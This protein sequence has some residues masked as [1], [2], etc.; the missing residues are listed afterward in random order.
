[1]H[2]PACKTTLLAPVKIEADLPAM[3]CPKC[4]GALLP[5]LYYRYWQERHATAENDSLEIGQPV[6]SEDSHTALNCPKCGRIMTKYKVKGEVGNRL[7][8][9]ASCD[10]AWLDHGEWVLLKS[11]E[12]HH[13]LPAV[14]TDAWQRKVRRETVEHDR[15]KR[16]VKLLGE[17][18]FSEAERIREWLASQPNRQ[19]ILEFILR[20]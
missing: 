19:Y 18:V 15:R 16:Y 4:G 12:L 20:D 10:E 11:L 14:F 13:Q 9:C 1:M 2:C 5:L 7:D 6:V 8:L 3:G 17:D